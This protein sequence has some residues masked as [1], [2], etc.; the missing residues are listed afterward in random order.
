MKCL[1]L[2]KE[3]DTGLSITMCFVREEAKRQSEI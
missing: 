2:R 3:L 1:V